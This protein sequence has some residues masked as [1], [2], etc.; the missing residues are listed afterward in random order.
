MSTE[1]PLR[2]VTYCG[3]YC[4]LCAERARIPMQAKQLEQS[5]HDERYDEFYSF[6]PWLKETY[7]KALEFLHVLAE[8]DC[9]CR[10]GKGGPPDCEMRKCAKAK[11]V[12]A[13]PLCPDYPCEHVER[14]AEYY[15]NL[16]Q[17][18]KRMRKIGVEKWIAEQEARVRRGLV[19]ADLRNQ[20]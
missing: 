19:Y 14:M 15:P 1:D 5:L 6:V 17:D 2:L 13:C 4:G 9:T 11:D 20:V 8:N 3:L 12:S 16:I 10:S 7:P 18:G